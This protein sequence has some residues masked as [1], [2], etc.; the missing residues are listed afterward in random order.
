MANF[1]NIVQWLLWQEDSHVNPGAIVNLNDGAG[2]TRLGITSKNFGLSVRGTF[3]S[4]LPFADA[5]QDAKQVYKNSYWNKF[6]G[7]SIASDLVAAPLLSFAV[8]KNVSIAVK[9]LQ[10]VLLV[11]PDGVLGPE[12]AHELNQKD[13]NVV[14]KMFRN[15]WIN[16]YHTVVQMNPSSG[17]FLEGWIN[18][19][20]FPYPAPWMPGIYA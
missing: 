7:D 15:E 18:R 6:N 3:F 13:P 5:V 19:A 1:P 8:N 4:T 14:A 10:H 16:F 17:R 9:T 20:N 2:Q 11:T 12:T